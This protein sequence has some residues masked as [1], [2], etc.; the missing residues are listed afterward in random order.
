MGR[1]YCVR[2]LVVLAIFSIIFSGELTAAEKTARPDYTNTIS[3]AR[4]TIWKAISS[5][6]GSG[7]TIAVM[8]QGRIIYSEGIGVADRAQNRAVDRNTRFNIGS[9][10]KMFAAVAVLL[11]VDE[12]K[13]ALDEAVARYIPEFTMKDER[14]KKITVRMLFN[15]SSGLPGSTFYFGYKPDARM[16]QI[17]LDTLKDA[18]LKH[19]P[20]AMSLYCNDGFTL[21]EMIVEK[22]SGK[23]YVDFLNQRIFTPL[24]MKNTSVSIGEI[25]DPNSAEFYDAK[26]GKKYPLLVIS[27]YGAGGM[28]STAEDL[29]RFGD[30]LSSKGKRI[31]S[32]ASIKEILTPQP[33]LFSGKLRGPQIMGQFGWEYS[34]I[35]DYRKKGIQVLGK[36]GHATGYTTNLQVVPQEGIVI[37]FSI[38]GDANG[39]AITRPILDA[40]MK[41][42]KLM[43]DRA[44]GV[45]RPVGPQLVPP[46]LTRYAGYYVDASSAVKI[47]F[48]KQ[49]NGFTITRLAAEGPDK[50]KPAA[51][52]SF[53]Y[54]SGYFY[55]DEEG[56]TY[57]FTTV[58]GKSLLISRG[59]PKPFDVDM[60]LYQKLEIMK[61]PARLHENMQGKIWLARDMPPYIQGSVMPA[62]SSL[63]KELPGYVDLMGIKKIENA[64]YAGI[65][66]TAFRDQTGISLFAKNGKTWIKWGGFLLST[67]DDIPKIKNSTTSI[68]IKEDNYNEWLKVEKGALLRFEKPAGGRLIVSTP[69]RALYD[70]IVD[71]GEMYAPAGSYIFCAGAAGDVFTIH[72]E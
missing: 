34:D 11:L 13:V 59:E 70:S 16:H 54:N 10:S 57:Y 24:G 23:K 17:L 64:N 49:K 62:S 36:G 19:D 37:G 4:E 42:R 60:I 33:A 22:V 9:T 51:S 12:G 71:S 28:S 38:S 44:S 21:A 3:V 6:Q 1:K 52:K 47:A 30:S 15:H 7:A 72:A 63:Y 5:G 31:L 20:G 35:A 46:G 61:T 43:E 66:A 26:T 29:C 65:A 18:Y 2:F 14:Y 69:D 55:G 48:N 68:R 8:D 39:E 50:Q 67:A 27:V 25:N 53:I 32:D 58:D 40:L 56:V 41:D 45:Q